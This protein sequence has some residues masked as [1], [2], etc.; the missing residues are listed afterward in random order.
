MFFA[1]N[2]LLVNMKIFIF[3]LVIAKFGIALQCPVKYN[4]M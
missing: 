3:N 1:I 4:V 2:G